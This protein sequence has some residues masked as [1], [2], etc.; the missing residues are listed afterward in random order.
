MPL[1]IADFFLMT[2]RE[3]LDYLESHTAQHQL[4]KDTE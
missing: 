1:T 4:S 2:E 3:K